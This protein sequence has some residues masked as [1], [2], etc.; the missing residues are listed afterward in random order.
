MDTL[1]FITNRYHLDLKK[2]VS[3]IVLP[4]SRWHDL[5]HLINDLDF[6]I[7]IEVGVFKGKF[8]ACLAKRAP[9]TK[10]I[11]LDSWA[12]YE[13]YKDDVENSLAQAQKEAIKTTKE[14]PNIELIKGWSDEVVNRFEDESLDFVYIDAN[15]S[16]E[17]VV[18]D[19][20]AWSKKVRKGGLVMGHDYKDDKKHAY[21]AKA[22]ADGWCSSY[23][24]KPLF[25]W[26]DNT[27]S[28]M[29]IK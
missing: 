11:G 15:H 9:N 1:Q 12:V 4:Q 26:T 5:G 19:I 17:F 7:G 21:G 28:W 2:A 25:I 14:L 24:I 3:P 27:P 13:G 22:A 16:Y 8:T 10:I 6:K 29:Y 23:N 20:A 18:A